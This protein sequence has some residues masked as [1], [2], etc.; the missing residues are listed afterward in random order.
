MLNSVQHTLSTLGMFAAFET[1]VCLLTDNIVL[2]VV[3]DFTHRQ[4]NCGQ[5]DGW[6]FLE[7]LRL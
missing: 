3:S 1:F 6:I 5:F 4:G 2:N 7:C